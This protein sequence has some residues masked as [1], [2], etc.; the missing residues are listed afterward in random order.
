MI[1]SSGR[2]GWANLQV[3]ISRKPFFLYPAAMQKNVPS[4]WGERVSKLYS[5]MTWRS[6]RD[7]G[8]KA[9]FDFNYDSALSDTMDS[10]RLALLSESQ[11][12][13]KEVMHEVSRR[14]F[15]EGK[16]LADRENLLEV[17]TMFGVVGAE[18]YLNSD[19]GLHE[20]L[21]SVRGW[22]ENG[23]HSIP[24]A[25]IRSGNVSQTV[26]GSANPTEFAR[27]FETVCI[28]HPHASNWD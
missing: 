13:Q 14:Y 25:I 6:I 18:E 2:P 20:V 27:A 5:P 22:T 24:V 3:D 28:Y 17:A 16:M 4:A 11:G 26:H 7:L 23:V 10:H 19:N 8:A 21:A 12:K 9:G 15:V 1:R